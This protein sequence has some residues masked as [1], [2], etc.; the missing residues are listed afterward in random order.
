MENL[1]SELYFIFVCFILIIISLILL[2]IVN[3][4]ELK[5]M[6]KP[7]LVLI[8]FIFIIAF[9]IRKD[10]NNN[11]QVDK[12]ILKFHNLYIKQNVTIL[13]DYII[14]VGDSRMKYLSQDE[15]LSLPVNMMF[16]AKPGAGM[17]WF[18]NVAIK[19]LENVLKH[20][21]KNRFYS[22]VF[23]MGVNDL[24]NYSSR[25]VIGESY[26]KI[27]KYFAL[28]YADVMFYIMSINPINDYSYRNK[29]FPKV[30][31]NKIIGTNRKLISLI[32]ENDVKNISYCDAFNSLDFGIYDGIHY[33]SKTNKKILSYI[34]NDCVL[35]GYK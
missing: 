14:V 27:Y 16:I 22:V 34:I 25:N 4:N 1:N 19:K 3:F 13:S 7:V 9:I 23:N 29:P 32:D 18:K 33:D 10:E 6:Y 20:K 12:N 24:G 5:R 2:Y 8:L 35:K 31:N 21:D 26:Y 15:S 11:F 17:D 28:K 30:T